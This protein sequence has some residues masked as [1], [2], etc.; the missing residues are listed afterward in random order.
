MRVDM[1]CVMEQVSNDKSLLI[2]RQRPCPKRVPFRTPFVFL[3]GA[4]RRSQRASS[5]VRGGATTIRRR[6][7]S[8]TGRTKRKRHDFGRAEEY[9]DKDFRFH[10][11]VQSAIHIQSCIQHRLSC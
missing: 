8:R 3:P 11:P 9:H 5:S 6:R 10:S 7:C 4:K 2:E 1:V